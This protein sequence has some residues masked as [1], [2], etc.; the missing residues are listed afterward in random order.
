MRKIDAEGASDG[1]C[2]P[3]EGGGGMVPEMGCVSKTMP[4]CEGTDTSCVG[5]CDGVMLFYVVASELAV[6][7]GERLAACEE[8]GDFK[9]MVRVDGTCVISCIEVGMVEAVDDVTGSAG[10][11]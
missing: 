11:G 7:T 8:K 3:S 9:G 1:M 2:R 10:S 6:G 5:G 4:G